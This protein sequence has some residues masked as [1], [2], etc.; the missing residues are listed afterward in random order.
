MA[1]GTS[2]LK[3][4]LDYRQLDELVRSAA[5]QLSQLGIHRG[6]LIAL[7]SDSTI[8]FAVGLLALLSSGAMV[9]PLNPALTLSDLRVRFSELPVRALL[10]PQHHA[11]QLTLWGTAASQAH[12]WIIGVDDSGASATVRLSSA[13]RAGAR[14]WRGWAGAFFAHQP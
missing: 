6:D 1:I 4:V 9:A 12:Q 11:A 5:K 3:L 14:V 10:V 13:G 7:I 8:E 2:D